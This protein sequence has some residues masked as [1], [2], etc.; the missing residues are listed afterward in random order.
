MEHGQTLR[1]AAAGASPRER[2]PRT[3]RLKGRLA[4]RRVYE[5]GE[6]HHGQRLVLFILR[7]ARS[8]R[9]VGFVSGRK[10]G[11]ATRRNRA[12]RLL[13]EAY[14]RLRPELVS[15]SDGPHFVIV[16]RRPLA[17]GSFQD[18]YSE[19]RR[20]LGAAG[21]LSHASR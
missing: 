14:R 16:A 17:D 1:S 9:R 4:F 13:R 11:P 10:V 21:E 5:Q 7:D 8:D 3:E 19:L 2:L 20:L 6:A 12:R 15:R 18:A